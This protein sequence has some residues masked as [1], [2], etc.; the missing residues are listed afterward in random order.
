MEYPMRL[1]MGYLT[2]YST[3]YDRKG[4]Y[5]VMYCIPDP[6]CSG[7]EL[8]HPW[9]VVAQSCAGINSDET[10]WPAFGN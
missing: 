5:A 9:Q 8:V 3:I 4:F 7:I 6:M 10:T 1:S 2:G